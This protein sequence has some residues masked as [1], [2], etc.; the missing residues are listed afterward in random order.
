M[1]SMGMDD[2][3]LGHAKYLLMGVAEWRDLNQGTV[4]KITTDIERNSSI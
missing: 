2:S 3:K 1:S 4:V